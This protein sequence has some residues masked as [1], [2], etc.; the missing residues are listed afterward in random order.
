MSN[1]EPVAWRYRS[2]GRRGAKSVWYLDEAPPAAGQYEEVQPLGVIGE[3]TADA[4]LRPDD[5]VTCC[6]SNPDMVTHLKHKDCQ[7]EEPHK[8]DE[9][10]VV[11]PPTADAALRILDAARGSVAAQR[12]VDIHDRA[13]QYEVAIDEARAALAAHPAQGEK[14]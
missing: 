8:W 12:C 3:P 14:Q 11:H 5:E 7:R 9:C 2:I 6:L 4:A 1:R 10:G 13:R